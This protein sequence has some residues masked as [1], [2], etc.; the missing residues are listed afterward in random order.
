[1]LDA[2]NVMLTALK[3][4]EDGRGWIIRLYETAQKPTTRAALSINF[5]KP[6]SVRLAN[7]AEEDVGEV[8]VVG[9]AVKVTLKAN[10]LFT[11]RMN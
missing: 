5:V 3:R 10:E 9:N 8:P 1:M 6:K 11:L 7:L 4:A 2:D